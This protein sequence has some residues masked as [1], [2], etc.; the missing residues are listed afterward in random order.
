M[1]TV[2]VQ[3]NGQR[4]LKVRDLT[5]GVTYF[6]RV[7]ARTVSYG[8][9]LQ[10]N[11][12]AGPAEGKWPRGQTGPRPRRPRHRSGTAPTRG[13]APVGAEPART[14]DCRA[15]RR[16]EG[17]RRGAPAGRSDL[18]SEPVGVRGGEFWF[19]FWRKKKL[20]EIIGCGISSKIHRKISVFT[21]TKSSSPR[22]VSGP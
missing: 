19:V 5:R 14:W 1:V 6:F 22:K 10:A 16:H 20:K 18:P 2:D 15:A 7:Q 11:V 17:P 8:P 3:G 4:W 9:E 12:T 21:V 13:I